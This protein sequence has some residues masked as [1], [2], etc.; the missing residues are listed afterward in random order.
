MGAYRLTR[1]DNQR[2]VRLAHPETYQVETRESEA[3]A[4]HENQN[5]TLVLYNAR[6]S[7]FFQALMSLS[8]GTCL[9]SVLCL[10]VT[11]S[12]PTSFLGLYSA[13]ALTVSTSFQI[14]LIGAP[15]SV[16]FLLID[17]RISWTLGVAALF[18]TSLV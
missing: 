13:Y 11:L 6:I 9:L 16:G 10:P 14:I 4:P 7:N 18:G 2:F 17:K 5:R 12:D 15:I 8:G 3:E 1:L